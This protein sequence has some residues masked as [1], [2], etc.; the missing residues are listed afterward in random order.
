MANEAVPISL[1]PTMNAVRRTVPNAVGIEKYTLL[2]L[3]DPNTVAASSGTACV[4]G[5]IAAAE[6]VA[7]DSSTSIAC[8]MDGVF[9][10]YYLG[11]PLV[12]GGPVKISGAN[13][14]TAAN[15]STDLSGGLIIGYAEETATAAAETIRVRLV[16][17]SL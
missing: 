6:K 12:A 14:I 11:F 15:L 9:D 13:T 8:Y 2:Q 3:Y 5:G 10:L 1:S 16:G 4:F 17:G 7:N